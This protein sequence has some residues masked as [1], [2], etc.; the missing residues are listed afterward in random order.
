MTTRM[1]TAPGPLDPLDPTRTPPEALLLGF[2][3]AL[4]AAGVPVTADRETAL[5][6][7]V[8]LVGLDDGTRTYWA[9]RATLCSAPEQIERYDRVFAAWFH[10]ARPGRAV[11]PPGPTPVP[12]ASLGDQDASGVED[13][14]SDGQPLRTRASRADIL[15]HRDVGSMSAR[16][17]AELAVLFG[18]LPQP[19]PT[20]RSARRT[21]WHR[22]EIDARRTLR[23]HLDRWGEP[24]GLAWR[25]R[26]VTPRRIVL[27]LDVSG[28]MAPYADALLR[29]AHRWSARG[30]A[31]RDVHVLTMGTRLTDVTRALRRSDPEQALVAVGDVV[32]DWSGGTR[33]GETLKAFLD[34]RGRRGMARGAVVVVFSD[35]W[36]R[37]GAELLGEQMARLQAVAHRVVWVNP[38]KGKDGYLPVQQG[39]TAVLPHCDDF[40]AGHS[41]ATFEALAELVDRA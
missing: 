35:G 8:A 33:L 19:L 11:S 14:T 28:S 9:G 37:G 34:Q 18:R 27:L 26:A 31:R 23:A 15:R 24:A 4:R 16:E 7:A 38:H 2:A 30:R 36:E 1:P 40:V 29:L 17:K 3:R 6:E 32:P 25:R 20:R 10:G 21:G 13:E 12:M 41:L 5:L 22:G 39:I